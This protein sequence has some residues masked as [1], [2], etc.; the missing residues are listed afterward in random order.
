[1]KYL[2]GL[3]L[4]FCCLSFTN[5]P[6]QEAAKNKF[7]DAALRQIYTLQDE[8][9]TGALLPWL[10]H[11]KALYRQE[12]AQALA[13]VQDKA[14][15]P[16][17][18]PL[19]TDPEPAVRQAAAYALGQTFDPGAEEALLQA[20]MTEAAMAVKA[21]LLEALGKCASQ[22]GLDYLAALS[23]G[24]EKEKAGQA[25]GIYRSN[26][27][28]LN[29]LAA[30]KKTV[31]LLQQTH[32]PEVRLGAAHFLARTPKL[33]LSPFGDPIIQSAFSDPEPDIRMAS[34][35]ALAKVKSA[36]ATASLLHLGQHDTDYRVRINALKAL[37]A[38]D[39]SLIKKVVYQALN[40]PQVYTALAA[41]E[42]LLAQAP[43]A[44]AENLFA[45]AQ[46]AANWRVR[47]ML[48]AAALKGSPDKGQVRAYVE[49]LYQ[50][51]N[52]LYEKGALLAALSQDVEA[53]AFVEAQAFSGSPV[54]GTYGLQALVDMRRN[55]AFPARLAASFAA[56]FRRAIASG[57]VALI[58]LA[59][60]ALQR[61]ELGF[62][63]AYQDFSFLKT[64]RNKLKLPRDMET[65]QELDK[66]I[67][68]F[69][70]L[71]PA[72]NPRNPFTHPL[73]WDLVQQLPARQQ[74][75]L[76]T[77]KGL[78]TLE[79]LVEA[80]PGSVANFVELLQAGFFNGR[81]FH[82][83]VP[84]FVVQ[85]GDPRGDGWGG[86]DYSI[87]TELAN[88]RYREGY[89]GMASAGKDTEGCQWFITHC[90]TP[91]LDGRYSIFAR[92]TGGLDLVHQ[93]E[94][95]DKIESCK[96]VN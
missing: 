69:E 15:I 13:S 78:I 88:L 34:A 92:V 40:D 44:E 37:S 70:G 75:H 77:S 79:L 74:V 43:A 5:P 90:P 45:R 46:Q 9:K 22:A 23:P 33:D 60:G 48:L 3:V 63:A 83:V 41:A 62:K 25:W 73:N 38:T 24:D 32:S 86:P 72:P 71:A 67:R 85:G 91:H 49:R 2:S 47:A 31:D 7:A 66:A 76:K 6:R 1:M 14:A 81:N 68:Y 10:K 27:K 42:L 54:L 58:G 29:Y 89:V 57:D 84:N 50:K 80:A 26:N 93:L 94:V 11:E 87:R 28:G 52:N 39:F 65:Y 18:L 16:A 21:E 17:L 55:T 51:S 56:L 53:Y 20:A 64:A 12:A 8:R 4:L 35:Q 59:A 19:L 30:T 95:G 96:L 36:E 82:R 61:P